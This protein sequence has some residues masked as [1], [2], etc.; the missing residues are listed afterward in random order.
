PLLAPA[1]E[2]DAPV[3]RAAPVELGTGVPAVGR[4]L[5]R[6]DPQHGLRGLEPVAPERPR[7]AEGAVEVERDGVRHTRP[8]ASARCQTT[9]PT[10]IPTP[11]MATSIGEPC[12]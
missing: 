5:R 4:E 11:S 1:C 8:R 10:A 12:R 9:R 6:G 3:S 7:V 2:E